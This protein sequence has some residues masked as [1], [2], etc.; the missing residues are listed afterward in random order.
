[1]RVDEG[2]QRQEAVVRNAENADASVSLGNVLHQPVNRVVR[3][4]GMVHVG[5]VLR[6]VQRTIH[7]VVAFGTVLAANVLDHAN[8]SAFDN[9]VGGVVVTVQDR[10]EIG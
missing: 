8:V 5:R 7:H 3:V 4:G 2:H 1:M 9:H 6:P 10:T